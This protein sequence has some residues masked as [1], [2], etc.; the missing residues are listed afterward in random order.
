MSVGVESHKVRFPRRL[1]SICNYSFIAAKCNLSSK[2][3][4]L[5]LWTLK[6]LIGTDRQEDKCFIFRTCSTSFTRQYISINIA[7]CKCYVLARWVFLAEQGGARETR[8]QLVAQQSR[9]NQGGERA[10]RANIFQQKNTYLPKT[11]IPGCFITE[12][13]FQS[14]DDDGSE[15]LRPRIVRCW[16]H[17]WAET[18]HSVAVSQ[19]LGPSGRCIRM[20]PPVIIIIVSI[21]CQLLKT[22]NSA[23]SYLVCHWSEQK[24]RYSIVQVLCII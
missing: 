20:I 17:W 13:P 1:Q 6:Y 24:C 4:A 5:S 21:T 9:P 16:H 2:C 14:D 3:F 15:R 8:L 12:R 7:H 10:H 11:K 19:I 18:Q 23:S 22:I